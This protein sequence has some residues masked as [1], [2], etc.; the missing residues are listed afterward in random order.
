MRRLS[1]LC[2]RPKAEDSPTGS[3]APAPVAAPVSP[4]T[5]C[6]VV[7]LSGGIPWMR[8]KMILFLLGAIVMRIVGLN[9]MG[10]LLSPNDA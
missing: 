5:A 3:P 2:H 6:D 10:A 9:L 1:T 8:V 7:R 4:D